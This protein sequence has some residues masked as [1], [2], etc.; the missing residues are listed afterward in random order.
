MYVDASCVYFEIYESGT[1][2][3]PDLH[4]AIV[5]TVNPQT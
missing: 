3:Q 5:T 1:G 2:R 4:R